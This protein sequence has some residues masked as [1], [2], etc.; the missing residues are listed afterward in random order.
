MAGVKSGFR[1]AAVLTLAAGGWFACS[2]NERPELPQE[3]VATTQQALDPSWTPGSLNPV[4]WY[5]ASPDHM[6]L[7]PD[8]ISVDRWPDIQ[9]GHDVRS[10]DSGKPQFSP[11]GWAPNEGSVHFNG[12]QLLHLDTWADTPAGT[13]TPLTVL[14]VIK[15]VAA[16]DGDV[17]EVVGWWDPNGGGTAWA[18]IKGADGRTLADMGRSFGASEAQTYS[19]TPTISARPRTSLPGNTCRMLK[20]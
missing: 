4:A 16:A 2:S 7:N 19:Y 14:A 11:N 3:V 15:S 8:G 18:G 10:F 1:V 12:T 6:G 9:N 13:N 5:V 17:R 20:P